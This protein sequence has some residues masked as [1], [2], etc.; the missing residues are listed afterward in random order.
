MTIDALAAQIRENARNRRTGQ[1]GHHLHNIDPTVT[2]NGAP[3][4]EAHP[5]ESLNALLAGHGV[6]VD[7]LVQVVPESVTEARRKLVNLRGEPG[8]AIRHVRIH[9]GNAPQNYPGEHTRVAGPKDGRPIV[10]H[11]TSGL[12][13]LK[14]ESGKAIVFADSRWGNSIDVADGAELVV[15]GKPDTKIT[16]TVDAGGKYTAVCPS[17]ENRFNVFGPGEVRQLFGEPEEQAAE[18][19]EQV[20]R[21][22]P[23][24][25]DRLCDECGEVIDESDKH[26]MDCKCSCGNTLNDG[27]GWD[28]KCGTCADAAEADGEYDENEDDEVNLVCAME[29]IDE[30]GDIVDYSIVRLEESRYEVESTGDPILEFDYVGDEEAHDAIQ[31]AALEALKLA[32]H[33]FTEP[34][35]AVSDPEPGW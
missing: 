35:T 3:A 34:E 13:R 25:A 24:N 33:K 8:G 10:I 15:Y 7:S 23:A 16:G 1:F 22:E 4:P 12:T 31:E 5:Y 17:S 27:N 20:D 30:E 29:L 11:L 28:G 9:D 14:V 18:P 32:G 26:C 21:P 2:L 19:G 6:D